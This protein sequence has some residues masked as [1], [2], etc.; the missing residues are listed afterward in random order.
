MVVTH[1]SQETIDYGKKFAHVL[2]EKD[3]V[4]LTG[5]LG[6]GKTTFVQGVL[7]GFALKN[8]ALS[9]TFTLM[10]E[11]HAVKMDVYHVDLY[12]IGA[13]DV[14]GIGLDDYLYAAKSVTLIEWGEKIIELLPQY[15][16]VTFS[17]RDQE[18]RRIEFSQKGF[19]NR[20]LI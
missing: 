1:S 8:H 19:K 17:F 4:I 11:Y 14:P 16:Q 20:T 18:E 7:A 12:R 10:R 5:A 9:P 6:A 3:V 2:R 13:G 15:I